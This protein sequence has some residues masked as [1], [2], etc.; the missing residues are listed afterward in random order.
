MSK[1]NFNKVKEQKNQKKKLNRE[2]IIGEENIQYHLEFDLYK[3]Q[4]ILVHKRKDE[5]QVAL[6]KLEIYKGKVS[7]LI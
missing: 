4:V 2:N 6:A 3:V 5:K 7:C 1:A